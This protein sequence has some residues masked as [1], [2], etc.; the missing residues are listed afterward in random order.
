[1][2]HYYRRL[3]ALRKSSEYKETFTYGTFIPAYE[4]TETIMAYYRSTAEQRILVAANFGKETVS[5]HLEYDVKKV[6][7]S[8][9]VSD[10]VCAAE[11]ILKLNSC[12]VVVLECGQPV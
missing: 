9:A 8:N 4:N 3:L 5:L 11:N 6:L 12:E 2:L 7:L 10:N 1:M